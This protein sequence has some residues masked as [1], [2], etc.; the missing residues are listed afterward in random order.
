MFKVAIGS[1]IKG[2]L[3]QQTCWTDICETICK[4]VPAGH[5]SRQG[6]VICRHHQLA[7]D[8]LSHRHESQRKKLA[9]YSSSQTMSFQRAT[10]RTWPLPAAIAAELP[11]S[12]DAFGHRLPLLAQ[13]SVVGNMA[14]SDTVPP[15]LPQLGR[16]AGH[17][18]SAFLLQMR[19]SGLQLAP[20][21]PKLPH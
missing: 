1:P 5:L 12:S 10:W 17:E 14:C 2:R 19:M 7:S 11:K 9:Q 15:G 18:R 21:I 20:A 3:W 8:N 4:I 13:S 16:L 6:S